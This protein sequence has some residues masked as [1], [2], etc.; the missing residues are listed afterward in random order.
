MKVLVTG[1]SGLIGTE[2]IRV[3]KQQGHTTDAWKRG[4]KVSVS[5]M[6]TY[7]AVVNLAGATTGKFN[8]LEDKNH[9]DVSGSH[10]RL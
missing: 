8:R 1:A 7:D 6:E 10:K 2:L 5:E 4:T 9:G 3:L